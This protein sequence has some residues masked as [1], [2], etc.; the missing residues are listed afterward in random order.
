MYTPADY[1]RIRAER[2]LPGIRIP[3]RR[4]PLR[5]LDLHTLAL[6]MNK[7][8]IQFGANPPPPGIVPLKI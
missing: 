7:C 4:Y 3:G 2:R 8:H 5:T 1:T 6:A